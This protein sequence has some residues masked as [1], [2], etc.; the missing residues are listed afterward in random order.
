MMPLIKGFCSL[1]LSCFTPSSSS[2]KVDLI[3]SDQ[4]CDKEASSGNRSSVPIIVPHFPIKSQ[5]LRL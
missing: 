1:F 2:L 5:P 3:S 4:D